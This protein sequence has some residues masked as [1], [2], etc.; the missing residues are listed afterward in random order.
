MEEEK[1]VSIEERIPKLK[2]SRRKKANRTLLLYLTLFFIL[3]TII[4][5]LQSPLGHIKE[6]KVSGNNMIPAE[7]IVK[8][9]NLKTDTNIWRVY[10]SEI[11]KNINE[12]PLIA[13]VT[14]KRQLPQTMAV[15][16]T[17][18]RVIGYMKN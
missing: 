18:H 2:Q 6:I 1:I 9:S 15:T 14:V 3:I 17:E 13:E 7:Q 12:H 16:V 4:I 10:T 5:Y 8:Y 11:E